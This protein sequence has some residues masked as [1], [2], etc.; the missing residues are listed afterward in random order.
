MECEFLEDYLLKMLLCSCLYSWCLS[1]MVLNFPGPFIWIYFT[2]HALQCPM[3]CSWPKK[4]NLEYEE[5]RNTRAHDE[6]IR[7]FFYMWRISSPN[8]HVILGS[9][10]CFGM[11]LCATNNCLCTGLSWLSQKVIFPAPRG[12]LTE[13]FWTHSLFR[14]TILADKGEIFHLEQTEARKTHTCETFGI[15]VYWVESWPSKINVHPELTE[16][17]LIWK[18]CLFRWYQVKMKLY[19]IRVG[20]NPIWLFSLWEEGNLGTEIQTYIWKMERW[21]Q[22]KLEEEKRI[23]PRGMGERMALPT[24]SFHIFEI[25]KNILKNNF[26]CLFTT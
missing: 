12:N 18:Y 14:Q 7:G 1:S 8:I 19:W 25:W 24:L 3:I 10:V 21:K 26:V 20:L 2:K 17:D 9:T 15:P 6:I 11:F 5:T 23:L 22:Q 16:Y 4:W 13:L